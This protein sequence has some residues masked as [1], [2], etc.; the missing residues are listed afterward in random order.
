MDNGEKLWQM[1]KSTLDEIKATQIRTEE[2]IDELT[3]KVGAKPCEKHRARLDALKDR[4]NWLYVF[5][6]GVIV[7]IVVQLF[8]G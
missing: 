5:L 2:K 8:A 4:V 1:V 3:D 7:A 6:G